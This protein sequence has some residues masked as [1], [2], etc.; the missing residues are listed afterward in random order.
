MNKIFS[1]STT[2]AEIGKISSAII[3]ICDN[4]GEFTRSDLQGAIEAEVIA[5]FKAGQRYAA[6]LLAK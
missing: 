3:E 2:H 6:D 1:D 5:A 4:Q